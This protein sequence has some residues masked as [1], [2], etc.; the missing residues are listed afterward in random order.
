M[1]GVVTALQNIWRTGNKHLSFFNCCMRSRMSLFFQENGHTQIVREKWKNMLPEEDIFLVSCD[2]MSQL[3]CHLLGQQ[4]FQHLDEN[5]NQSSTYW[6]VVAIPM[7]QGLAIFIT[8]RNGFFLVTTRRNNGMKMIWWKAHPPV[9]AAIKTPSLVKVVCRSSMLPNV[10][11]IRLATAT[12]NVL[13]RWWH[14]LSCHSTKRNLCN[15]LLRGKCFETVVHL[16]TG[17]SSD[18]PTFKSKN[19][20]FWSG[21]SA[22]QKRSFLCVSVVRTILILVARLFQAKDLAKGTY[23]INHLVMIKIMSVRDWKK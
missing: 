16:P 11:A 15:F 10:D 12:G 7:S 20:F 23:H 9:T 4:T 8:I 14:V 5:S 6:L 22:M 19:V 3:C 18:W 1:A 2:W 17:M 13:K 21:L